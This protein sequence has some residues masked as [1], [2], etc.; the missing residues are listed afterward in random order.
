M[1]DYYKF[2]NVDSH[3]FDKNILEKQLAPS[4]KNQQEGHWKL[5]GERSSLFSQSIHDWLDTCGCE[6]DSAEVFYTRNKYD[7]IWHTDMN[8][9]VDNVKI[10][11]VW[12]ASMNHTMQWGEIKNPVVG[13]LS[14]TTTANTSW[15]AYTPNEVQFAKEITITKP[16]LVNVGKPHRVLVPSAEARWC[17]CLI[18]RYHNK[19]RILF[20]DAL[21]IFKEVIVNE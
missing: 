20:N 10:N 8:P 14:S 21:E 17:L 11:F 12:S 19:K 4:M 1:N 6:V 9:P 2:L 3:C 15:V 18:P 16:I 13:K 5:W 7:R